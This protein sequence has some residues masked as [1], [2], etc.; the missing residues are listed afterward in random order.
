MEQTALDF[1]AALA[2][3]DVGVLAVSVNNATWLEE[4][5][6]D[7]VRFAAVRHEFKIEDFRAYREQRRAEPPRH[8]NAWGALARVASN[9]GLI[10]FERYEKARSVKTH[11]HPVAV[12]RWAA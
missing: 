3:R 9:R 11:C 4:A 12:Y 7:L 2:A 10:K 6:D 8:F 5:L 1:N